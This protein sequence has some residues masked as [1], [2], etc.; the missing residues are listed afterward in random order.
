M[1]L[2]ATKVGLELHDRV[3]APAGQTSDAA[4]EELLEAL[5]QVGAAGKLGGV[6]VFVA[7]LAEVH[8][9]EVGGELRLLVAATR[10]I[11]MRRRDLAPR[12]QRSSGRRFDERTS[13]SSLLAARLLV[14]DEPPQLRAHPSDLVGL[15]S[16]DGSEE[17]R[18]GIERAL[19]VIAGEGR[20][21][22][23]LVPPVS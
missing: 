11:G 22:C 23:P 21:V 5:G 4:H 12:L 10:H 2:P 8:L 7:A 3:A 19:R 16:G 13:G 15:R 17:A 1:R 9:P 14:D 18:R 20:L 6:A